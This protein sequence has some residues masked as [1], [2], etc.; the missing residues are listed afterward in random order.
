MV[1]QAEYENKIIKFQSD[2]NSNLYEINFLAKERDGNLLTAQRNLDFEWGAKQ[3][4]IRNKKIE[5]YLK[6]NEALK[7][8]M[9]NFQKQTAQDE[10]D[11]Q[12]KAIRIAIADQVRLEQEKIIQSQENQEIIMIE[13]PSTIIQEPIKEKSFALGSLS[14]VALAI[15]GFLVLR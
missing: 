8:E 12:I 4:D 7:A 10:Q 14:L 2:I 5:Q 3:A 9:W 11:A 15:G 1:T 6:N 13:E